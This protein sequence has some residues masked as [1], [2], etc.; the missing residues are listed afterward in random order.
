VPKRY[1]QAFR[2][3]VLDLLKA[4]RSVAAVAADL[5]LSTQTIYNWREARAGCAIRGAAG[6]RTPARSVAQARAAALGWSAST[7]AAHSSRRRT[8]LRG[9]WRGDGPWFDSADLPY[10]CMALDLLPAAPSADVYWAVAGWEECREH[11]NQG[12]HH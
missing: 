5:D 8:L 9:T 2:R 11:E 10:G 4:G 12:S 7:R 3:K 6:R 1:P